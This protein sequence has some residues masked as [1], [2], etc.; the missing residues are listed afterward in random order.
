MQ[1][2]EMIF[3]YKTVLKRAAIKAKV[4]GKDEFIFEGTENIEKLKK[5]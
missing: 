3:V 1:M 2:R 4:A 5:F